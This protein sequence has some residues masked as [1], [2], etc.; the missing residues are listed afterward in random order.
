MLFPNATQHSTFLTLNQT[1]DHF[2]VLDPRHDFW[3][4]QNSKRSLWFRHCSIPGCGSF[5]FHS[6]YS[7]IFKKCLVILLFMLFALIFIFLYIFKLFYLIYVCIWYIHV[8]AMRGRWTWP[9]GQPK[10]TSPTTFPMASGSC[11]RLASS[12]MLSTTRAVRS[13]SLTSPSPSLSGR[14]ITHT[15]IT[16]SIINHR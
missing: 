8:F 13:P 2:I 7:C 3:H 10:W 9:T 12:G 14:D 1:L 6:L 5:S 11:W 16:T 15:S 4:Q